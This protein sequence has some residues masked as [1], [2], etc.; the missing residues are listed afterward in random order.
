MPAPK[1][2]LDLDRFATSELR[3]MLDIADEVKSQGAFRGD[4]HQARSGTG[5]PVTR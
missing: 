2:F 5:S 3:E 4:A 1:H